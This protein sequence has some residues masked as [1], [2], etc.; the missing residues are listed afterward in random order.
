[1]V[2]KKQEPSVLD[3]V[4]SRLFFWR[5]VKIEIPEEVGDTHVFIASEDKVG[6]TDI[7]EALD[8]QISTDGD[9]SFWLKKHLLTE[10]RGKLR[11]AL[12]GFLA[13]VF[14]FLAQLALE[15]PSR[16]TEIAIF[17]YGISGG[18]L[19]VLA[20][21]GYWSL[22]DIPKA[23][24]QIDPLTVNKIALWLSIP[25][26]AIAF[27]SFGGNRFTGL[28]VLLWIFAFF[29][30]LRAFWLPKGEKRGIWIRTKIKVQQF[31][32]NGIVIP[33]WIWLFLAGFALVT[34]F[35]FYR[36]NEVPKEMF[37]D[38]AEK[39]LDVMD[40]L[41]GETHIFFARNTGR[42]AF[43]FYLT[44]AIIKVFNTGIS[45]LSL[46]IGTALAGLLTL[47]FIYL[48]GKEISNRRVGFLAMILAGIAYWPN[49]ISRVALRFTL[50]PFFAAPAIFYMVRGIRR[51]SRNDMI[52]SGIAV[53][54]GLHGYSPARIVPLIIAGLV[55]LYLLHKESQGGRKQVLLGL[56][57]LSF[58]SLIIFLPLLRYMLS[59]PEMFSYRALTRMTSIEHP[60][61]GPAWE[62]FL[63]NL[64]SASIMFYWDNGE[65]WVHSIPH[66]PALGVV[67]AA[68]LFIG[69]LALIIRYIKQ[70]NWIDIFLLGS[71]PLLMLPSVLSLA[72]PAENPSL[73]R[74]AGAIIPVFIVVGLGVDSMMG[75]FE[76]SI[77]K[78]WGKNLAL[79][80]C[81]FILAISAQ[82]NYD[83]VFNK[84]D[85]EFKQGAWNSSEMGQ[86]IGLFAHT[87]GTE[88]SAWV[89]PYPYWV[90][91]RLVGIKAGYPGKD[92][93]LFP[94]DIEETLTDKGA[95]MFLL[96]PEDQNTLD[97]L[98]SLYPSGSEKRYHSSVEGRD[99]W[100][101]F[102]PPEEKNESDP[103]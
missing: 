87:I 33:S 58:V 102:V 76:R 40:V 63:K 23:E 100:I 4:K 6:G 11:A 13:L 19:L 9:E 8:A 90:D 32:E 55:I 46:K 101:F 15:P 30:Y 27:L 75:F 44:A 48:L 24:Q 5:G 14:A 67:S 99:F 34:F 96:K 72:F 89:I 43:Q 25:L 20:I 56:I 3:Y 38:H 66:R 52:L 17:F 70:H 2:Q 71:I 31:F 83:L 94:E 22:A 21:K 35:R 78:P 93:A 53:G 81:V 16:N 69:S 65:I 57:L 18:I 85:L 73:N 68:F 82:Q 47:P 95:K 50:Y 59:N 97:R 45:F 37:S 41:S 28:N 51:R 88:D 39:L 62:I 12:A 98:S 29:A 92:Y 103:Y 49:V 77:Q 42:E 7:Y 74:T 26:I 1:M 84:Y 80:L 10:N 86:V 91:T 36:L 60:L 61:P 54:L 64:W 79:A